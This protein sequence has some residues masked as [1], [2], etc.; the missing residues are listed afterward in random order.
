MGV[1]RGGRMSV[2]GLLTALGGLLKKGGLSW[3]II[4]S[5]LWAIRL[6]LQTV[7][8]LTGSI[9]RRLFTLVWRSTVAF[10]GMPYH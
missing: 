4:D 3:F 8:Y 5:F 9:S 6:S 10:S 1:H 7:K 2:F